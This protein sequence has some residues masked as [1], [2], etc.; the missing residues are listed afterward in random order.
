MEEQ[1]IS[2]KYDGPS[3]NIQKHQIDARLLA[4]ALDSF[5]NLISAA[6]SA[7]Y[8]HDSEIQVKAQAGFVK[9]SF[10][11]E[12]IVLADLSVLQAIGLIA[13]G[14]AGS[15]LSILMGLKGATVGNVE[16]EEG[17]D[18]AKVVTTKGDVI[19][20]TIASAKL[21]E[22]MEVRATLDKL[23]YQ[24]LINEGI[25]SFSVYS[26]SLDDCLTH[27][28]EP[29]F[30]V[31]TD[32]SVFYRKPDSTQIQKK[33]VAETKAVVEFVAANRESG[34]SGWRMN[35]LSEEGVSVKILDE[36]FLNKIKMSN[37]PRFF[38]EKF[39]VEI[40]TE[41]TKSRG[42]VIRKSYKITK[43]IGPK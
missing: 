28:Q 6:D 7:I 13:S 25:T 33:T 10:G 32:N 1:I 38:S 22:S 17:S 18:I 39:N 23:V 30:E 35:Y 20:T 8:G 24:P 37:A 36:V 34:T 2:F 9:G 27:E 41:I 12:L 40:K 26:G 16:V 29:T 42:K 21:I 14:A 5:S 4:S 43:V 11:V 15:A 19:N 31:T 3:E